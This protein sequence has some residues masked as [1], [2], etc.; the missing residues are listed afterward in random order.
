M[1]DDD[2]FGPV[3][4]VGEGRIAGR[5]VARKMLDAL[6]GAGSFRTRVMETPQGTVTLRSKDGMPQMTLKRT[7]EK[8]E[9]EIQE[10]FALYV[11]LF[12]SCYGL[13][14]TG[15]A[16]ECRVGVFRKTESFV[17]HP[18]DPLFLVR[19]VLR[20]LD[21][22]DRII[23]VWLLDVHKVTA[24]M[25]AQTISEEG[26]INR[27]EYIYWD[28]RY[29]KE[30]SA[31]HPF[32]WDKLGVDPKWG[33]EETGEGFIRLWRPNAIWRNGGAFP[34]FGHLD[35]RFD[36]FIVIPVQKREGKVWVGPWYHG[37]L[38]V[39][40]GVLKIGEHV[41]EKDPKDNY[42]EPYE[43]PVTPSLRVV[44][45]SGRP[46]EPD[47]GQRNYIL[48]PGRSGNF[49]YD[50]VGKCSLALT[51][52]L[53]ECQ[54]K[55]NIYICDDGTRYLVG[56]QA[57]FVRHGYTPSDGRIYDVFITAYAASPFPWSSELYGE[58]TTTIG[59]FTFTLTIDHSGEPQSDLEYSPSG[60]KLLLLIG[61]EIDYGFLDL[62]DWCGELIFSGGSKEAPPSVELHELHDFRETHS[63]SIEVFDMPIPG[64]S[65]DSSYTILSGDG[66]DDNPR[67]IEQKS[68]AT[69]KPT[70][71]N[72]SFEPWYEYSRR[73]ENH[74]SF[75]MLISYGA[76]DEL[77]FLRYTQS[78]YLDN[79]VDTI[80]TSSA[81]GV[82]VTREYLSPF[83][84]SEIVSETEGTL[85]LSKPRV[86]RI[87]RFCYELRLNDK[88]IFEDERT[89]T[90]TFRYMFVEKPF[91]MGYL[92]SY[93][94]ITFTGTRSS[95]AALTDLPEQRDGDN[96]YEWYG[97]NLSA[98]NKAYV[99][100]LHRYVFWH[101][102][103]DTGGHDPSLDPPD[104]R[105]VIVITLDGE[106]RHLTEQEYEDSLYYTNSDR[107]FRP[108]AC[109][110]P[111][112]KRLSLTPYTTWF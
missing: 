56:V 8:E 71:W 12:H 90:L 44:N 22:L 53:S 63:E 18:L 3:F 9:G 108:W 106:V 110:D 101:E 93:D 28:W 34:N 43:R 14:T 59:T 64:L 103:W 79:E 95:V 67:I 51:N 37:Q 54:G 2:K 81:T 6:G 13:F 107:G 21:S 85:T 47:E 89:N 105:P 19:D 77:K 69:C 100:T 70:L 15:A 111:V 55:G 61:T 66:S 16:D 20:P 92:T 33:E 41:F 60:K 36:E 40:N 45:Y 26:L 27:S 31:S 109:Y 50:P 29:Q 23:D 46:P 84:P 58:P 88:I 7:E 17:P 39:E 52:M 98:A 35:D 75:L 57:R 78:V 76:D 97:H 80:E 42:V 86:R 25:R 112:E 73:I 65:W 68:T 4:P 96:H 94:S 10:L 24:D 1:Y 49:R 99:G 48:T 30:Y 38:S 74:D 87:R 5:S 83:K 72:Q 102:G 104:H 91:A 82:T 11:P 32:T 62:L